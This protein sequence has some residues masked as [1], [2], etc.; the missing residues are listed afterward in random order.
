MPLT[1]LMASF[2]SFPYLKGLFSFQLCG[3]KQQLL[4]H[5]IALGVL[6]QPPSTAMVTNILVLTKK[7]QAPQA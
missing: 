1:L 5:L 6:P 4:L 3:D 2:D 7:Q